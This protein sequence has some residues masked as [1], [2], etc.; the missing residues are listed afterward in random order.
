MKY[1]EKLIAC[2]TAVG[3]RSVSHVEH[4]KKE[5][6]IVWEEDGGND[7]IA[8]GKHCEKSTTGVVDL[9]TKIE[10]DPWKEL[11]EEGFDASE[12]AWSYNDM[13]YEEDTGF[14]HHQWRWN[15][16]NG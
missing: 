8:D 14:F 13:D 10:F 7:L 6:Y 15:I 1:Y 16:I 5:R 12:I 2:L 4:L 3:G 11:I 9:F